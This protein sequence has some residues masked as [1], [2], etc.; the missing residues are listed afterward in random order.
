MEALSLND[1]LNSRHVDK[2][3]IQEIPDGVFDGNPK[4][5]EL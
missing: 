1:H 3:K 4:L 5:E 2:T